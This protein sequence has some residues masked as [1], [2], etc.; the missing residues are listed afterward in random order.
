MTTV[1]IDIE[2]EVPPFLIEPIQTAGIFIAIVGVA[3]ILSCAL[4]AWL[5][6]DDLESARKGIFGALLGFL[7]LIAGILIFWLV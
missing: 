4:Y 2:P 5:R 7:P 6:R 3:I 1:V